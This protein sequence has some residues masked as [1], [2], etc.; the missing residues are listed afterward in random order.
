MLHDGGEMLY[1]VLY[2]VRRDKLRVPDDINWEMGH[3]SDERLST[4]S[5]ISALMYSSIQACLVTGISS[6][7][8]IPTRTFLMLQ[9]CD[10]IAS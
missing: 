8:V 7:F 6:M 3:A 1:N 5:T 10:M 2:A 4:L 9:G